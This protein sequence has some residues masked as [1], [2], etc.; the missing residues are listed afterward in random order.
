MRRSKR[1]KIDTQADSDKDTTSFVVVTN[2]WS[3]LSDEVILS[4][5][6]LLPQKDLV[7]VSVMNKKFRD[8]SRDVSLWTKLTLDYEDIKRSADSCRKLVDRCM[9]LASLKITNK[10][11]NLKALNIMSVVIRAKKSLKSL[12]VDESIRKWSNVAMEKLFQLKELKSLSATFASNNDYNKLHQL[13][14]LDQLE[15]L[16]VRNRM[17][18][19]RGRTPT[20][21]ME[22]VL[23]HFKKLKKVDIE[24]ADAT[25][26]AVLTSNSPNLEVLCLQHWKSPGNFPKVVSDADLHILSNMYPRINFEISNYWSKL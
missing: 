6:R 26:V 19:A 8:L 3:R 11:R 16:C 9:K 5:F 1:I 20:W 7:T 22:K 2:H 15:M 14:K 4:I 12:Y 23:P 24:V 18:N 17:G 25:I 10:S 13:T 21:V